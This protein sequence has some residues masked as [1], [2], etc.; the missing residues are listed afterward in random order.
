MIRVRG[1]GLDV[2]WQPLLSVW[3]EDETQVKALGVQDMN[4][5]RSCGVP[6]ADPQTCIH[7]EGGLLQV[8]S[9]TTSSREQGHPQG[10]SS[11]EAGRVNDLHLC[12]LQCSTLCSVNSSSLLLCHSPAVPD[13]ALPKRVFF[14]L[15]NMQVDF[16][17]ASGGQGF[18][19]QPNPRLVPLSHEGITHPHRLKPG[20]VLDV[21]VSMPPARHCP[22]T[23]HP[24]EEGVGSGDGPTGSGSCYVSQG[25]GLN[26]GITKEEVQVHIGDGECLVK[27]LTLTHLY[28]EP[29]SQA[30]QPTNGS[31]TLPQLVVSVCPWWMGPVLQAHA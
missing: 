14:S 11:E 16:A 20:H 18:L 2:V 4:P 5:R 29:P 10:M 19:Y 1:T 23:H 30:P 25:E 7:L 9:P 12:L 27:T 26:L 13:G 31:G 6:A 15:D 22:C 28:C 3:L 8:S 24:E 17:S 21:E